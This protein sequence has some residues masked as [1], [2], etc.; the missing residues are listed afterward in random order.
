MFMILQDDTFSIT[1]K[2]Q[3]LKRKDGDK[4]GGKVKSIVGTKFRTRTGCLTCK[5]RKRK[6]DEHHPSCNYCHS[7]GVECV[8]VNTPLQGTKPIRPESDSEAP[9]IQQID[10]SEPPLYELLLTDPSFNQT[11][12]SLISMPSPVTEKQLNSDLEYIENILNEPN[13]GTLIKLH[14]DPTTNEDQFEYMIS[15]TS[16]HPTAFPSL[17]LDD[18]GRSYFEFFHVKVSKFLALSDG[19][20]NYFSNF[21]CTL[22]NNE[23]SFLYALTSWGALYAGHDDTK[24]KVYLNKAL[25]T[26]D[27]NFQAK[28][29][30]EIYFRLCFSVVLIGYYVCFGEVV[31]W[32]GIHDN[33]CRIL[34]DLG[35]LYK[36]G[37]LYGFTNEARFIISNVQYVDVMSAYNHKYG[38]Q[39]SVGEYK[40][41][42]GCNEIQRNEL[43]YGIDTLQGVHQSIYLVLADL[44]N[45]KVELNKKLKELQMFSDTD[46]H[47]F[48]CLK[49]ELYQMYGTVIKKLETSIEEAEPN[50]SLLELIKDQPQEH[51]AYLNSFKLYQ[52]TCRL[53]FKL[54]LKKI[55]PK[56]ME[57]QLL[58]RE[59]YEAAEKLENTRFCVILCLP[60][61]MCGV[62]CVD[63]FDRETI[64]K[65][66][67]RLKQ[68]SPVLNNHKTWLLILKSWELN[69]CG[70]FVVDWADIADEYGWFLNLC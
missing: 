11:E 60:M 21:L 67:Q 61:L 27:N 1:G 20:M 13:D 22:A 9:K 39:F 35:G 18:E 44:M 53:Y 68:T 17:F 62:C 24:V 52:S 69:P 51:D 33:C 26:F 4:Y 19:P 29:P 45:A 38:T 43:S 34:K 5:K 55:P 36:F 63:K 16:L 64:E 50:Y 15:P 14:E 7:R 47:R 46:E 58:V 31:T 42:L 10:H 2:K 37:K 32:K 6:C 28:N 12:Q 66:I 65:K 57:I 25:N 56:N 59:V 48:Y 49:E 40:E 30:S 41:F 23:E 70:E 8:Y 3:P 54:F